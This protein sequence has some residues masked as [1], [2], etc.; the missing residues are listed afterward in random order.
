[1]LR[2]LLEEWAEIKA[3][4]VTEILPAEHGYEGSVDLVMKRLARLRPAKVRPA[5]K[6]G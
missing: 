6:T 4:R 2:Q 5:Q 3:P 1:V